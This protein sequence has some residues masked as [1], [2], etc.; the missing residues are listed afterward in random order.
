MF[1]PIEGSQV[2]GS[3]L[4]FS[5]AVRAHGFVFVSGQASV[6]DQGRLEPGTIEKEVRQSFDNVKRILRA[7]G[8]G[9][10][11]VVQVRAYVRDPDDLPVYNDVYRELFT[12]SHPARTTLTGCLPESMRFEVDVVAVDPHE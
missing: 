5:P 4:P 3:H 1:E 6:D 11:D 12:S 8:L 2:P 7:A 10:A 9:L